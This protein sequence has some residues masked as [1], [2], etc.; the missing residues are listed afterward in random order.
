MPR[1][2]ERRTNWLKI[3]QRASR[4][5]RGQILCAEKKTVERLQLRLHAGEFERLQSDRYAKALAA[6]DNGR[7]A[8]AQSSRLL[9][10]T[11]VA[12]DARRRSISSLQRQF[13]FISA[14]GASKV[15]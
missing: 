3:K 6:D 9:R 7:A 10:A 4:A 12:D 15:T 14:M 11:T 1:A 13:A 8:R 2:H 5:A